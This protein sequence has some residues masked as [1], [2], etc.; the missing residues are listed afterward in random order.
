MALGFVFGFFILWLGLFAGLVFLC[1]FGLYRMAQHA[2]IP[3]PWLAFLPVAQMYVMGLLAERS[4]YVYSGGRRRRLAR[5]GVI[6]QLLPFA[7]ML[8]MMVFFLPI[9]LNGGGDETIL[10]LL[11][12]LYF[13]SFL[14]AM[15][16]SVYCTYYIFRDYAPDNAVLY[17]IVGTLLNISVIFFL[18]E[19]NTVPVSV[20]GFGVYPYGRPKYDRYHRWYQQPPP[21]L[22]PGGP[23]PNTT[24]PEW[25]GRG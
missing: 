11:M 3:S 15:V 12:P 9:A 24:G 22:G 23:G 7:M 14:F 25:Y 8:V 10:M 18:V 17:T 13:L 21:P 20:T 6:S 2:G 5:W 4:Y 19:R 1:G 16:L